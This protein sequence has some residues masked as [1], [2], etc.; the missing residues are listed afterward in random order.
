MLLLACGACKLRQVTWLA[1]WGSRCALETLTTS[2]IY[3]IVLHLA[4][5]PAAGC[6][7]GA[8]CEYAKH[9]VA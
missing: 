8:C 6:L 9:D 3:F 1:C 5:D 7:A 4:L 2:A